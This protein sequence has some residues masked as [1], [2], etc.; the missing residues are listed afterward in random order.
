M[1][2]STR[3]NTVARIEI[4]VLEFPS[5]SCAS[6]FKCK[7]NCNAMRGCPKM[8]DKVSKVRYELWDLT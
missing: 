7:C 4:R 2:C 1:G 6:E 3:S 8:V 5:S